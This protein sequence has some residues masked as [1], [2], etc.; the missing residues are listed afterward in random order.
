MSDAPACKFELV[1]VTGRF[2]P[3]HTDHLG[4]LL[5]ALSIG[6][7]LI[8]CITNPDDR[9]LQKVTS[10][11]HRHLRS[12]NPFSYFERLQM[13]DTAL[14]AAGVAADRYAIV[15]FPLEEPAEWFVYVPAGTS[16][17]VRTYSDWERDK[18]GRLEA[19]G[20]PVIL[21]EGNPQRRV[22]ATAIRA[23]MSV[24]EPWSQWVPSGTREFLEEIGEAELQRRCSVQ[25]E[26]LE[27]Q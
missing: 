22:S 23:A 12:S 10:S 19:A 2:Q 6:D 4:L 27:T 18:A 9:S 20:Y 14:R 11:A 21:L 24:T 16:Q 25:D 26:V 8:V 1:A 15:P 17:I 3:F 7:R 13:I 5:H